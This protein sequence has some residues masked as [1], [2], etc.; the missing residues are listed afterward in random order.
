MDW[1]QNRAAQTACK[2]YFIMMITCMCMLHL[3]GVVDQ[4]P[5]WR[6]VSRFSHS[7]NVECCIAAGERAHHPCRPRRRNHLRYCAAC[8]SAIH[9]SEETI[10]DPGQK[11]PKTTKNNQKQPKTKMA[12]SW[13]RD[14]CRFRTKTTC[15][16][17]VERY[18]PVDLKNETTSH[19]H[20]IMG[21]K[22]NKLR[23]NSG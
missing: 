18:R 2:D 11:Q 23:R 21:Q 19:T 1:T 16:I 22:L 14:H 6:S 17:W 10:A 15:T 8:S 13:W 12:K 9:Q 20:N 3:N 5:G 4:E 7:V